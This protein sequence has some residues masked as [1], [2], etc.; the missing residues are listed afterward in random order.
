MLA[1]LHIEFF[2]NL[3]KQALQQ[4]QPQRARLAFERGVQH[5]RRQPAP[6]PYQ[7]QLKQLEALLSMP[8][9]W[10]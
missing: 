7:A 10:C 9:H 5:I 4:N 1:I 8:T 2:T 6:A 3:G